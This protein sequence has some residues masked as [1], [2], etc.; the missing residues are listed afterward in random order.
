V[1]HYGG[2]ASDPNP[3]CPDLDDAH[4]ELSAALRWARDFASEL[5]L[6]FWTEWFDRALAVGD[7]IDHHPDMLPATLAPAARHLAAMAARAHVFGAMGSWNDQYFS[8]PDDQ[9]RFG[10]V[11]RRLYAAIQTAFLASVNSDLDSSSRSSGSSWA[12][13]W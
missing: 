6:S 1:E 4:G 7:D 11:S 13:R 2:P 9:S 3:R 10:E 12:W 5:E 8:E